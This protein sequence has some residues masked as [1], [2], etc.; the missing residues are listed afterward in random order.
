[1]VIILAHL[2]GVYG[3][4]HFGDELIKQIPVV[5]TLFVLSYLLYWLEFPLALAIVYPV[6]ISYYNVLLFHK[7]MQLRNIRITALA[8]IGVGWIATSA[9]NA[10][11]LEH[12]L[13]VA[14]GVLGIFSLVYPFY[15]RRV[16]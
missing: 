12:Q 1:M 3:A 7:L 14:V 2:I 15:F 11:A 4:Y 8:M 5:L 6:V 9:A 16:A 13:W 10:I